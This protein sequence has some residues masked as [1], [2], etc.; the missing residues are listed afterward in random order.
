VPPNVKTLL[1]SGFGKDIADLFENAVKAEDI[2]ADAR[3][4]VRA[5]VEG[6]LARMR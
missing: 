3:D 6:V 5:F 4:E 1:S 2:D